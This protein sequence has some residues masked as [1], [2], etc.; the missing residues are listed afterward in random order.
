M[1]MKLTAA[2]DQ[3]ILA[4]RAN[5]RARNTTYNVQGGL[6][7]WQRQVG[8]INLHQ[9]AASAIPY[10]SQRLDILAHN[11]GVVEFQRFC[12]FFRWC[13]RQHWIP[14]N[15]L[16]GLSPPRTMETPVTVLSDAQIRALLAAG[17]LYDRAA[18]LLMLGSG[19]R[20]G[21][22]TA[23]RWADCVDG[24]L[25]VH[26][27]GSKVRRVAPG[28][29]AMGALKNLPHK[30]AR[31][32]PMTVGVL[33]WR[34]AR[35]AERTCIPFH[36]HLLRHSFAM[37]FIHLGGT[38]EE[39]SRLLG[40]AKLDTTLIYLRADSEERALAAQ[41]AHNPADALLGGGA[42]KVIPFRPLLQETPRTPPYFS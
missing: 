29:V 38:I 24:R 17:D 14:D 20:V 42:G 15:P 30:D 22:V 41:K 28:M 32:F 40:H 31:V 34:M 23:L 39:L 35:L 25:T 5:G 3:Y 4:L 19:M 8:D 9:A 10:L 6:R 36:A 1:G 26:G 21:E 7:A 2:I 33:K 27:K 12:G 18:V 11:S 13:V 37:R 16:E